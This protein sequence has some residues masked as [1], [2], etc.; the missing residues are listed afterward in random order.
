LVNLPEQLCDWSIRQNSFVIGPQ[1]VA[2]PKMDY[3]FCDWSIRQNNQAETE[4]CF[5]AEG[6]DL[7]M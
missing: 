7:D 6:V 1:R 4:M 2:C 3:A 5:S